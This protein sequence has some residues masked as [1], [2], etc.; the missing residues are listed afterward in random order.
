LLQCKV[1][2][3]ARA[4][5]HLLN[6]GFTIYNPEHKAKRLVRGRVETRTESV[7][8]G[9]LFIQLGEGS[10]WRKLHSTRGVSRVV[11]FNGRPHPV[12]QSLVDAL[13]SRFS[14]QISLEPLFE[15][16]QKVRVKEGCFKDIEAIVKAM[17]PD[18]R[19]IVLLEIMHRQQTVIMPAAQLVKAG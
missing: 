2:Q 19:V 4:Q 12:L 7:F 9:Y 8:P 5:L 16:G 14:G 10:D 18:D 15:Q 13:R 1:Q 11:S 6:Q 3:H 17:T